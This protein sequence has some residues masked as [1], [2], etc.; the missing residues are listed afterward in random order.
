MALLADVSPIT[1][2]L[3][4]AVSVVTG[5]VGT[6]LNFRRQRDRASR[7]YGLAILSEIKSLERAFRRYHGVLDAEAP[8]VRAARLPRLRLS[9][10]D[11]NVFGFNSGNIG[12]FSVRAAVEV[13]EFYSRVRALIAEAQALA[14]AHG[15]EAAPAPDL[16]EQLFEHL[17]NVVL[18]RQHGRA[19]A[20]LLRREL[21]VL[22]EDRMRYVRRRSRIVTMRWM[23]RLR[24]GQGAP[25]RTGADTSEPNPASEAAMSVV[26]PL[27]VLALLMAFGGQRAAWAQTTGAMPPPDPSPTIRPADGLRQVPPACPTAGST[28][29]RSPGPPIEYLGATAGNP[30]LCRVRFGGGP[31]F[32]LYFGIWADAWPGADEAYAALKQVIAGPLGTAVSFR[33]SAAPSAQW[34]DVIR[35][36]GVEDL[37][38]AGRVRPALKIAHYREGIEGNV[39][40]SVTTGWKEVSSGMMIYVSYRHISGRPEAGTA[41]DPVAITDAR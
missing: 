9:T 17:R 35:N 4:A 22:P 16:A 34:L 3:S 30:D 26:K 23:R 32:P 19:A 40:R 20:T 12:L 33:T 14:N 18:V 13:I 10:S 24:P 29:T 36:E 11:L 15:A 8:E 28:V 21:P 41:W 1:I 25:S 37:N 6:L 27:S 39:Y 7:M 2:G 38:V 5:Y 31:E